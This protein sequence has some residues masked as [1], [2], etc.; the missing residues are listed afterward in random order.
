[1]KTE[2]SEGGQN[3]LKRKEAQ[4]T[5]DDRRRTL[6]DMPGICEWIGGREGRVGNKQR[7]H[8]EEQKEGERRK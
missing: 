8:K 5:R 7:H 3:I 6:D 1:M 2:Q 4:E